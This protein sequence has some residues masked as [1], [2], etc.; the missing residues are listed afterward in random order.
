MD[1]VVPG[2]VGYHGRG[3]ELAAQMEGLT[4][5]QVQAPILDLI[6][7]RPATILDVGAGSGRD[8]AALAAMGHTVVAVEPTSDMRDAGRRIHA[9]K[10]I[11]WLD[12]ALPELACLV[13]SSPGFFALVMATA[14]W[15][16]LDTAERQ[17]AMQVIAGLLQKPG[18]LILSLRHGPV[19]EGRRMFAVSAE[20]TIE[21]AAQNGLH[22]IRRETR[23]DPQRRAGVSW[24]VL[25]FQ[26]A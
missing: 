1:S 6:P 8:A 3:A 11:T 17:R 7:S 15:M 18:L 4:F 19:P 9:G 13:G 2:T 12:G 14:V 5:E 16:H 20:E 10:A 22:L 21:V 25:A 23:S 26:T 24:T